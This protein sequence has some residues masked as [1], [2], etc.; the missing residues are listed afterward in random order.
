MVPIRFWIR[1][2]QDGTYHI[3]SKLIKKTFKSTQNNSISA[4]FNYNEN[5]LIN[6]NLAAEGLKMYNRTEYMRRI[7]VQLTNNAT[8]K[9]VKTKN[10]YCAVSF[11]LN[12]AQEHLL[13]FLHWR[14]M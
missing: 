3:D 5:Q 11:Q 6:I 1:I 8:V 2:L 13:C 14:T 9:V 4:N 12:S 10:K 7:P